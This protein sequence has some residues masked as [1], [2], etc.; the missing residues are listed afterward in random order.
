M[1]TPRFSFFVSLALRFLSFYLIF[2]RSCMFFGF[3]TYTFAESFSIVQTLSGNYLAAIN[4]KPRFFE[5]CLVDSNS[6]LFYFL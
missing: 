4:Y 2:D 1:S 3:Q 6:S 5:S